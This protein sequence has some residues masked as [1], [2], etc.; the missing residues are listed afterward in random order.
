MA[1]RSKK[2]RLIGALGELNSLLVA[3]SGGVDSALLL[4]AAREA[5]GPRVVA[6]TAISPIHPEREQDE[7]IQFVREREIDHILF[8][9]DE[10]ELP[11]FVA[12]RADRCYHCKTVFADKL[13]HIAKEMGIDYVA[14][15]ANADDLTD[16]RPGLRAAR[17]SGIMAPLVDAALSKDEI[18]LLAREMGLSAWDKPAMACLASRFP[19]GCAI[20]EEG[21]HQVEAGEAFLADQG[22]KGVRVRFY[23]PLARIEVDP[24][25]MKRMMGDPMRSA[26]VTGFRQI[27]FEHIALDMEGYMPGKMNRDIEG[28]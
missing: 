2:E 28:W 14:H 17:E 20:T 24:S 23:G 25:D 11:E 5:L 9:T 18:R 1:V 16:Y 13:L 19:Y 21:L 27:G 10:M 15:G 7:A 3:F 6:A 22:F 4:S 26:V 12:N 8:Q